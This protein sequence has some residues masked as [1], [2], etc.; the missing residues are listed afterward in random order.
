[1]TTL[2][3]ITTFLVIAQI[4]L[5]PR[6]YDRCNDYD[7]DCRKF[8]EIGFLQKYCIE[9]IAF[10]SYILGLI[11]YFVVLLT[12]LNTNKDDDPG[13]I[14]Y[15]CIIFLSINTYSIGRILAFILNITLVFPIKFLIVLPILW[16]DDLIMGNLMKY[17]NESKSR[18]YLNNSLQLFHFIIK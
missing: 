1:M 14:A 3:I 15:S 17:K 8:K 9:I 5:S 7:D 12:L 10:G 11:I 6:L 2:F 16:I 4:V 13:L 18:E